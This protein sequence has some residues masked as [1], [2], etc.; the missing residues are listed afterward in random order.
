MLAGTDPAGR[1]RHGEAAHGRHEPPVYDD[2]WI[3][4][5]VDRA[6][7]TWEGSS[8]VRLDQL[9]FTGLLDSFGM[10]LGW[11]VFS[12]LALQA[13]GLAGVGAYSAAM[14]VGVALSAPATAWL[15]PRLGAGALLRTTSGV[16]AALR[17]AS[18]ALLLAGAP[19]AVVA[20][21]VVVMY[22]SGLACYAGM[23]AEVSAASPPGRVAATMT[24]FV[25]A[26]LAVEAAGVASAALLPG[27]PPGTAGGLLLGVVAFYGLSPL[28]VWLV[29]RGARVGRAP[30]RG[31]R[32]G[33][34]RAWLPLLAGALIM[35]VGSGPALLAVG[36]A[37][38][39]YGSRW[40]AGAALAFT[41]GALLAPW[42]V[43]LLER[44][45]LPASVTW[46]AWGA[47]MLLGWVVAPR[48]VAGL[49]L[50][51]VLAGLCVAAFE[52]SMDAFVAAR[53]ARAHLTGSLAASEAVRALGSAAAV[54]TLPEVVGARSI[55]GFSGVASATLL[56]ATVVAVAARWWTRSAPA[57]RPR[58][59][60]GG[61]PA[62]LPAMAFSMAGAP[63]GMPGALGATWAVQP[64]SGG[65][66]QGHVTARTGGST[67]SPPVSDRRW[68]RMNGEG[69]QAPPA[70]DWPWSPKHS[71]PRSRRRPFL[72]WALGVVLLAAVGGVMF[73]V[74]QAVDPGRPAGAQP[75]P[76]Y[77]RAVIAAP[78]TRPPAP[79]TTAAPLPRVLNLITRN[80]GTEQNPDRVYLQRGAVGIADA[81]QGR[82][83]QFVV[84]RG[85]LLKMRV[86]NQDRFI[87]SFTF[88]KARVNLDA[89]EGTITSATFKAPSTPGTY[90]FYCRYRK[91]GM[92]GTLV[93]Q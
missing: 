22:A 53:Q 79:A 86:D 24:L 87:H 72:R 85:Q 88:A 54:A 84:R 33:R 44:W 18:F 20:G 17:V 55:A 93:V 42:A 45:R 80:I 49:I 52:G 5:G 15:S 75:A 41:A 56:A 47:G 62:R 11:T 38:E 3:R 71:R 51:Q 78:T 32:R 61:E 70:D 35:L 23:R 10:T 58:R 36:L 40:V 90:Q 7:L 64:A 82:H 73:Q 74:G 26:I 34:A 77:Q 81:R 27:E 2:Q 83:P 16:E 30:R 37:A 48:H 68:T 76:T 21:V 29:A 19:V 12:L 60:R 13:H 91:L 14:L 67:G 6:T 57:P 69:R 63:S 8:L 50:A 9:L 46:P 31:A 66:P 59:A 4:R 43:A 25:T 1:P 65:R 39:L 28:S 92:S 89:W